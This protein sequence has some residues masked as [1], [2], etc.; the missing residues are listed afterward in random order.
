MENSKALAGKSIRQ[1]MKMRAGGFRRS[2]RVHVPAG[3]DP[4]QQY[5]LVVVLHGAFSTGKEMEKHSGFSGLADREGFLVLYPNG[6]TLFGLLQH[7]NAGHCCGKAAAD[8]V[9]DV[10]YLKAAIREVS[11]RLSVDPARIYMTRFSNGGMMTHRFGA[12]QAGMLAAIAPLAGS[13]GG[14][15]GP[16]APFWQIPE[17]NVPLPVVIMHGQADEQVPYRG[18][19]AEGRETGRQFVSVQGSADFWARANG[20]HHPPEEMQLH[21]GTVRLTVWRGCRNGA[22]VRLYA[23][24]DWGHAW[25]GPPFTDDL[26]PDDPFRDFHTAETV[27]EFFKTRRREGRYLPGQP[28]AQ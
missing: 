2:Y 28:V 9:D 24:K 20:C 3:Y 16:G 14:S 4:L 18:G 21:G 7:W 22:E 23:W 25:P 8:N 27:W 13:T 5:P 6:I 10:G 12:E 19:G 11:E 26:D 1:K 17:P 15:A